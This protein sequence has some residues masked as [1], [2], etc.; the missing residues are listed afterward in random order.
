MGMGKGTYYAAI[1]CDTSEQYDH[2]IC[3]DVDFGVGFAH[4]KSMCAFRQ[5]FVCEKIVTYPHVSQIHLPHSHKKPTRL[6]ETV[7][8]T[9]Q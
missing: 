7:Q 9:A 5:D 6:Q 3:T 1:C 2:A 8:K 4:G